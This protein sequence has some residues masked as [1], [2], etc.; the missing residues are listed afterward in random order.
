MLATAVWVS[1]THQ[2]AQ[3]ATA[4]TITVA[5]AATAVTKHCDDVI[6]VQDR[7]VIVLAHSTF[8]AGV[9]LSVCRAPAVQCV[10][11]APKIRIKRLEVRWAWL[12]LLWTT[13]IFCPSNTNNSVV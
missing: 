3:H 13:A 6:Q 1:V 12:P 11:H 7:P 10:H 5:I 2:L 4:T 9:V 8:P